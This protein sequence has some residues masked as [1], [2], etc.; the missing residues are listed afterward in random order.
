MSAALTP[1]FMVLQGNQLESL[2][3]VLLQWLASQPLAP[4]ENE[5]LLVQSNGI[6]QWFKQALAQSPARGGVGISAALEAQLP[7]QFMWQAYRAV[8][9]KDAVPKHSPFDKARLTWRILRVLP[10][11]LTRAS[12]APLRDFLGDDP[13]LRKRHQL[14][15]RLAD[16]YDQY[17]VYRADWLN[18][19]AQSLWQTNDALGHAQPLAEDQ[20][21]QAE[22]WATLQDDVPAAS[23][24]SHRA[25]LHQRFV[26][27]LTDAPQRPVGLPRRIVVF[28]ISSLAQSLLEALAALGRHCQVILAVQ[29]PC[30]HFWADIIEHR[31][32]LR[33]AQRRQA[34]KPGMPTVLAEAELHLHAHPLLASWGK[35]GRDYIR[36]LDQFDQPEHYRH[37]FN[38][39]RIDL[40]IPR[41]EPHLLAQLH[42]AILDLAPTPSSPAVL[43]QVD[44]SVRFIQAHSRQREVE[45]LHDKL[46]ALFAQHAQAGTALEPR[47]VI[48]MLPDVEQYAPHVQAVFGQYAQQDPR[49]IPFTL[50]DQNQRGRLPLLQALEQLLELPQARCRVSDVLTLLDV[51]AL[52][53][54]F[55]LHESSLPQLKRWVEGAGIRWGLDA[56]QRAA[57][58]LPDDLEQNTWAFGLERLLLGYLAGNGAPW[59]DIEPYAEVGGLDAA[60]LGPLLDLLAQLR[61]YSGELAN[62]ANPETW[63]ARLTQLLDDLF[64]A[65]DDSDEQLLAS[66]R[67]HLEHWQQACAEARL[68]EPLPLAVVREAWLA[69]VDAPNLSQRF[70][71]GSV[72]FC[73][74]MPMRAIPF[75]VIALLGMNDGD[76][77]RSRAPLEFDLMGKPGHY[78]PGDRSRREDDRYLFLEALLAARDHL[79]LSWIGHDVRDNSERPPSVLVAQLQDD[80][81]ARFAL[82]DDQPLLEA[83]SESHPL[84]PFSRRYFADEAKPAWLFSYAREWQQLHQTQREAAPQQALAPLTAGGSV[85]LRQLGQFL[86]NPV[87][88]FY[89]QRLGVNFDE[90]EV[91]SADLEPFALDGLSRHQLQQQLLDHALAAPL[92]EQQ[93]VVSARLQRLQGQGVLPLGGFAELNRDSLHAP[94]SQ[95]LEHWQLLCQHWPQPLPA[96]EL[97]FEHGAWRVED[98]LEHC[99]QSPDQQRARLLHSLSRLLNKGS[100][101]VEKLLDAWL[102]HV[103]SH[104][105]GQAL[106]TWIASPDT[107]VELTPLPQAMARDYLTQLLDLYQQGLCEPLPVAQHSALVYLA[108]LAEKDEPYA[109]GKAASTYDNG[110]QSGEVGRCAY[111]SHAYPDFAALN[112]SERFAALAEQLYG[113][114]LT[115]AHS[116]NPS[117]WESRA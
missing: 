109:L 83:L 31:E 77:P 33:A 41:S 10:T 75:R 42:N 62:A 20:R 84:Q 9:G 18:D 82:A 67:Q 71:A 95:L 46:L 99:Q 50:A 104:A 24:D 81:R 17:Q 34:L 72:N 2:R 60:A 70:L 52:R 85:T 69:A 8:L 45:I 94:L 113:A 86:R 78:R 107:L 28:G 56:S 32:L 114:L 88:H 43:A 21:W 92:A 98:W 26:Q 100:L 103:L 14:A 30:Q 59:A 105:Q 111:L 117:E 96:Q 19:W 108:Q 74:L 79:L 5:V 29:N 91:T 110:H 90:P 12:F 115:S 61:H 51:P 53:K 27:A 15:E 76:Y 93:A 49:F 63:A 66:L 57:L 64:S 11:L 48:V 44:D 102:A 47:E 25:A 3:D 65:A 54:R 36:L 4:L 106:S 7:A 116:I 38:A 35:Q 58:G 1:G 13:E 73:T 37:A 40:F 39:E 68:D 97:L 89:Q 80:L 6:A 22:L 101:R 112:A 23:R 16:L 87:R 55:D